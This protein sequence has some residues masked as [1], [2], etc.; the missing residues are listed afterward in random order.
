MDGRVSALLAITIILGVSTFLMKITY[1][2]Q[3]TRYNKIKPFNNNSTTT[4]PCTPTRSA[5][6]IQI[7]RQT[8]LRDYCHN[9]S[10]KVKSRSTGF[11][12]RNTPIYSDTVY[13]GIPKAA[14]T[15]WKR[16]MAAFDGTLLNIRL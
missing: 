11:L 9:R 14:C 15:G 4:T 6:D 13:C 10:D 16:M 3:D 7:E 12:N 8:R 2:Q 5:P 1:V